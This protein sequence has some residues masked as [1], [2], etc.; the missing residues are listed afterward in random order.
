MC[1]MF[2]PVS[3]LPYH[4]ENL[5]LK[6]EVKCRFGCKIIAKDLEKHEMSHLRKSFVNGQSPNFMV[7]R[8]D[9]FQ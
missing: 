5:C 1:G 8:F 3:E 6:R 4:K 9:I 2:M 7:V